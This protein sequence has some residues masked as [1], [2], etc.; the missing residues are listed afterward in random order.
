MLLGKDGVFTPLL[1]EFL[2]EAMNGK[3]EDLIEEQEEPNRKNGKGRRQVKTPVGK[4][5]I[6]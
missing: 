5:E 4:I 6:V 1:K 3:L 2:D